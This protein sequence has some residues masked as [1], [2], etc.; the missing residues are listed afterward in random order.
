MRTGPKALVGLGL[1]AA[2]RPHTP[3]KGVGGRQARLTVPAGKF[4]SDV[5]GFPLPVDLSDMP[6]SFW[7]T[8]RSD[9]ANIRATTQ[10]GVPLPTDL[11]SFNYYAKTGTLYVRS[12]FAAASS[13]TIRLTWADGLTA[14]PAKNASDGQYA[15]WAGYDLVLPLNAAFDNHA[16]AGTALNIGSAKMLAYSSDTFSMNAHQGAQWDGTYWHVIDTATLTKYT[17]AGAQVLQSTTILAEAS[18]MSGL[19]GLAHMGD[20]PVVGNTLFLPCEIVGAPITTATKQCI[21]G[22]D[23]TTYAVVSVWDVS[24]TLGTK[25][26]GALAY[27]PDD[28]LLYGMSFDGTMTQ[29]KFSPVD[30]SYQGSVTLTNGTDITLTQVQGLIW[31]NGAWAI[32][33][34]NSYITQVLLDGTV[35]GTLYM[36]T[37]GG[38]SHEGLCIYQGKL[39]R[40]K[41]ARGV[42]G[43]ARVELFVPV[44][45]VLD[46]GMSS[47]PNT[48]QKITGLP[49][50]TTFTLGVRAALTSLTQAAALSYVNNAAGATNRRATVYPYRSSGTAPLAAGLWDSFGNTW[51]QATS[52]V[53]PTLNQVYH[54]HGVW[55]GSTSRL[56]YIDGVL[57]G[58]QAGPTAPVNDLDAVWVGCENSKLG[59]RLPGRAGF[60]YLYNGVLPAA[61]LAAEVAAANDPGSMYSIA[62]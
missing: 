12:D 2:L 61:Y 15:V 24:A 37:A 25:E 31:W 50:R 4:A 1:P 49:S 23:I 33:C 28:G 26:F 20:G 7:T 3:D 18:A 53:T 21:V 36:N 29:W 51:L 22:I 9:G 47:F 11:W 46:V 6:A 54:Q 30:G 19:T 16:A 59:E 58:T 56:E 48:G 27:Q 60:A 14:R 43:T 17:E 35:T 38:T 13:T 44:N 42:G 45:T 10:A 57:V 41:D 5:V 52:K 32:S 39:G 55:N 40:L 8:V 34:E 62:T